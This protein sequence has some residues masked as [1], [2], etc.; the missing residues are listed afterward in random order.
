MS[1]TN[2]IREYKKISENIFNKKL[3][4]LIFDRKR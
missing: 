4:D 3:I 2:T 1:V